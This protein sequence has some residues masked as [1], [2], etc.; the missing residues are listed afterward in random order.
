[1]REYVCV[2]EREREMG[3]SWRK[4][5]RERERERERT[6]TTMSETISK[7]SSQASENT[8]IVKQILECNESAE[9]SYADLPEDPL[10]LKPTYPKLWK[11]SLC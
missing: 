9:R 10:G 3:D 6:H 1:M 11:W 2:V 7:I 4:K 8:E 5:E